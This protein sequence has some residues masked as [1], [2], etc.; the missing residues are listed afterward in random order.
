MPLQAIFEDTNG[1]AN[2]VYEINEPVNVVLSAHTGAA[3]I[4]RT[5]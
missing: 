2:T 4:S 3:K 5:R 1:R